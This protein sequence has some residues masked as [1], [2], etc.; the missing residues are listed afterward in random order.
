MVVA[1]I[2]Q[3]RGRIVKP[4]PPAGYMF[5]GVVRHPVTATR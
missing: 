1:M 2:D 4:L 3:P 5:G